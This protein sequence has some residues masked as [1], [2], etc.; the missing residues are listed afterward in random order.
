MPKK[1][2]VIDG[3]SLMHRA[4]HAV[5]QTMNAPDGRP[6]NAVFGFIAMLLKFIDIASPDALICAFDAGRPA[7]RMEALEQY[8][9]QRPPMDDDLKVQFPIIEELLEAMNVPVVRIKGWEGDDVLGTIAARDE[10]LGYET[11]LV[12]GDKDAYQLA[13]DMTRIVTTKKGITDVAIYGPAEVLERYGVRPDQFIDFL[14][15]KGDSSDNIPGVPGIGDK[16]AAKLLQTYGSLEGI[17]EHVDD[18]KGKQKE[19]IVDNK[20]MA[21]LS[22]DVATIVRDLDFPLDLEACSF[23]S[24]DSE[25]VTEAFKGV[26]FNAHLGRVLKLVGKELEKKAAPLAVEPVVSG[27]E[28]HALVDAAVARGETVGVAFI[29]PEQVSLFNAGLHC[30]VNTSEGTAL[31]EDDEGREAFARIVRAVRQVCDVAEDAPVAMRS[32]IANVSGATM[33]FFR[34]AGVTRFDFEMLSLNPVDFVR[35]NR[36]DNL[37]DLPI[38]CDHFLHSYANDTLGLVLAFGHDASEGGDGAL[39]VRRTALAAARSHATHAELVRVAD[40]LAA[41][42]DEVARQ[43]DE[44]RGALTEHGFME[45]LPLRFARA[46]K[47]DRFAQM[48][49]A[50]VPQ[51]GFGLGAITRIDGAESVNTRDLARYCAAEG[52]FAKITEEVRKTR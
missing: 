43:L 2:A 35:L 40:E 36:V 14:G 39:N 7:F 9:S 38:I 16:T 48:A 24:F 44:M 23:P 30:A 29:E 1:I 28:A 51:I 11:L 31:F 33:P 19:K 21:F 13:T 37:N 25:K 42:C 6:T 10:E 47:E 50:G 18:L 26:Q 52:D 8:K 5:P 49:A 32:S 45:Y 3:N 17:Y 15:L 20:D 41:G 27:S 46:G 22:R 34:R 4:Y 12:T